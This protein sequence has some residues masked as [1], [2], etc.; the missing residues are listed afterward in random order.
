MILSLTN[1]GPLQQVESR[2]PEAPNL[3]NLLYHHFQ[4]K[5]WAIFLHHWEDIVFSLFVSLMISAIAYFVL[6][7]KNLIPT[8]GQSL[9]ELLVEQLQ[10]LILGVLGPEGKKYLPFLGTLFIYIFSMNILGIIPLMKSPSSN[11]NITAALAIC[12][13][14]FVQYLNV[15]NMGFFGF[16]YHMAGSPK[17]WIEWAL[18][19]L[20]FALEIIA[21]LARPLTLALRLFGN[22]LGEEILIGA[23]VI[24]GVTIVSVLHSPVGLPL[25]T[26]F[27]FLA[28]LT[29]LMQALVFT[30]LATVYILLSIPHEEKH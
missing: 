27:M 18:A 8:K 25:Q 7:N 15:K 3:I 28:I 6:R 9:I 26:P 4:D 1:N 29:S 19:P 20:M 14:C 23:F 2:A 24:L 13:F 11:I 10:H 5:S 30:L 16:L 12:V 21:Q 22:V 17:N